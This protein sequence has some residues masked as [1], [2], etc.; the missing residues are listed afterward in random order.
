MAA[1]VLVTAWFENILPS[2]LRQC[3]TAGG[4]ADGLPA[5]VPC[6]RPGE[7]AGGHLL[8]GKEHVGDDFTDADAPRAL[9]ARVNDHC[10]GLVEPDEDGK[11]TRT[12]SAAMKAAS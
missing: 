9:C 5:S 8:T 11:L 4:A 10:W 6:D 12:C 2:E 7:P 1:S 3:L